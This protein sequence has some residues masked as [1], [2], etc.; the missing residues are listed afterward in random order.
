MFSGKCFDLGT[1]KLGSGGEG[2]RA[3]LLF[4]LYGSLHRFKDLLDKSVGRLYCAL[5]RLICIGFNSELSA[6]KSNVN[7]NFSDELDP[8]DRRGAE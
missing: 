1:R 2:D 8:Y 3:G 5:N 6:S 7:S 4:R